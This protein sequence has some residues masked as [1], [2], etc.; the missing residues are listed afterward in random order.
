MAALGHSRAVWARLTA[1]AEQVL[2][3]RGSLRFYGKN[4]GWALTFRSRG[5]T[6]LA[7]FPDR[8]SLTALVVLPETRVPEVCAGKLHVSTRA[9]I[10]A[11]KP[12]TEGRWLF[13]RVTSPAAAA[14]V[15]LLA[16]VKAS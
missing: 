11:T 16:R 12:I 5:R 9:V 8:E 2:R 3:A 7:L 10:D 4:H 14:D 1:F 6:A 15:E 13:L